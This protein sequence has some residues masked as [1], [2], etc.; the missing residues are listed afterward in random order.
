[1]LDKPIERSLYEERQGIFHH[2]ELANRSLFVASQLRDFER[3]LAEHGK[4]KSAKKRA[5]TKITSDTLAVT[6]YMQ[7]GR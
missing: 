5:E 6:W 7:S 1:V 2:L 4:A 3:A